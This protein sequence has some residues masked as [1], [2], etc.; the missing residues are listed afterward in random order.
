MQRYTPWFFSL[1]ILV[2][3]N[4]TFIGK[5]LP[6]CESE[7]ER[8]CLASSWRCSLPCEGHG[9][10]CPGVSCLA[11]L[12]WEVRGNQTFLSESESWLPP[13]LSFILELYFE[14]SFLVKF[15]QDVVLKLVYLCNSANTYSSLPVILGWKRILK[16]ATT[17]VLNIFL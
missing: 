16:V 8:V 14:A 3:S 2:L 4:T 13:F 10:Q 6:V 7:T 9:F 17:S 12:S 11:G 1:N 5:A 15:L